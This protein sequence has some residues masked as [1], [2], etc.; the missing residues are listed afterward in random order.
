MRIFAGPN[1][2]GKSTLIGR[3][4]LVK[5]NNVGID[6]GDFIKA[7]DIA[8]QLRHKGFDFNTF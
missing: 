5:F 2:A 8:L 1:G 6:L 7:D 4:R 3:I